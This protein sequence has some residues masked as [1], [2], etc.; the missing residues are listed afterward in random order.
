M[1]T[2]ESS[3]QSIVVLYK[4]QQTASHIASLRH[5]ETKNNPEGKVPSPDT[6]VHPECF[7]CLRRI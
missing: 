6:E 4:F 7:R 2:I 3:N 1:S 5:A